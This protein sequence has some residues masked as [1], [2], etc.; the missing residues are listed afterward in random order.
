MALGPPS[1]PLPAALGASIRYR[2]SSRLREADQVR[3][4]EREQLARELHDTVAHHVSAI[5][6]RAQ[7]G[8]TVA[9]SRP[10]AAV[11]ALAVIEEAASR[12]LADLRALVGT[13]R[14]GEDAD[15]APQRG[16][17]DIARLAGE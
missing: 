7:A 5:A 15:L 9:A 8:R 1:L 3:L 17:A 11:D 16:V 12:T 10:D 6:V 14:D 4:R 2:A 13:L